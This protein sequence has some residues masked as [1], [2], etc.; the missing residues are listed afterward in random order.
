MV[1]IDKEALEVKV[2]S[3]QIKTHFKTLWAK[4]LIFLAAFKVSINLYL[5]YPNSK[6]QINYKFMNFKMHS[7]FQFIVKQKFYFTFK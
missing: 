7:N 1:R 5:T 4:V 3:N 2:N 6:I